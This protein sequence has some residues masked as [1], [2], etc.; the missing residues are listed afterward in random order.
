MN[1]NIAGESPNINDV[2]IKCSNEQSLTTQIFTNS[3]FKSI[4]F[5]KVNFGNIPLGYT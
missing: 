2:K 5:E 1:L 3:T 4:F